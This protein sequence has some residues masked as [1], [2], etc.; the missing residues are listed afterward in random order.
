MVESSR[1]DVAIIGA[2]IGGY[3]S[4]IRSAQ[5]GK[6]VILIEKDVVGGTCL[7]RGCIP[8]KTLLA[9]TSFLDKVAKAEEL[10]VH[11]EGL[12]VDFGKVMAKKDA[13]ISRLIQGVEHLIKKNKVTLV[14]GK[15]ALVS[16][17]QIHVQ[18]PNGEEET[19]VAENIIIAT[20][21]EEPKPSYAEVDE[22]KIL[23]SRGALSLRKCPESLA[24]IGGDMFGIEFA[25]I[26]RALGANVKVFEPSSSLLSKLDADVGRYYERVLRKRGIEVHVDSTIKSVKVEPDGKVGI[27]AAIKGTETHVEVEKAL[28]ADTR[29]PATSSLGLEENGVTLKDGFAVVDNHQRTN[30]PNIYAVGDVTGGKMLA[31]VAYAEGIVAAEN[32][33]GKGSTMDHKTVPVC[34]YCEPEIACVGLSEDEAKQQ[35]HE[36]STGKFQLLASGRALTLSETDG[37]AKVVCDRETGEILGVHLI[38][39][40]ATELISEAA[41]AIKLEC[42]SEEIGELVHPHPTISEALM[43]AARAVSNKAIHI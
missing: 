36:V 43:E 13:V 24:V 23:T 15:A 37:F 21:S 22:D 3:V 16:R 34:L 39:P 27:D 7:N 18:K 28:I 33:A 32:V 42:T 35:G 4:A 2:G 29:R 26:F 1:Y 8:T 25:A 38:G 17:N 9:T 19:V 40:H 11:F 20:G 5:L 12:R 30:V 6:T 10:G 41:L 14:N 31:H